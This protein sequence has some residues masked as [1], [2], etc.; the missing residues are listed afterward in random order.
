MKLSVQLFWISA[1]LTLLHFSASAQH[2]TTTLDGR[3][4]WEFGINAG[5]AWQTSDVC[6][7]PGWGAGLTLG[8]NIYHRPGGLLD[9]DLRGRLLYTRTFGQEFETTSALASNPVFNGASGESLNY[10]SN[11][12]FLYQNFRTDL[13]ELSIEGVLTANRL[14][15]KTGVIFSVFGGAGLN[16]NYTRT[17]QLDQLG[18]AYDYSSIDSTQKKRA[19]F[20]DLA[21]LKDKTYETEAE[22]YEDGLR[23]SFMPS[24]GLG[25]GYQVTP[26]FSVG[27]EHK[28]NWALSD[29]LEGERWQSDFIQDDKKDL[30]HYTS[31]YLRWKVYPGKE[32]RHDPISTLDPVLS[33]PVITITRPSSNPFNTNTNKGNV[34][35]TVEHVTDKRNIKV[36]L[37]GRPVKNFS[38]NNGSGKLVTSVDL[39]PGS[40]NVEITATNSV[41]DD[42]AITTFVYN[43]PTAPSYPTTPSNPATSNPTT[44]NNNP[45]NG[46]NNPNNGNN[47]PSN[48][49]P[50]STNPED[51]EPGSYPQGGNTRRP[52]N[53]DIVFPT[54]NPYTTSSSN[55]KVQATITNI[56]SKN[57][58]TYT[59]NNVRS[60]NFTFNPS[61]NSFISNTT[62]K[63]G[64]TVVKITA[65]NS[66]GSDSDTQKIKYT[67]PFTEGP[68]V[69][70]VQPTANPY[71]SSTSSVQIKANTKGVKSKNEIQYTINGKNVTTYT[72]NPTK[73][74]IVA[75]HKLSPGNNNIIIKV[76]N[77]S[78]TDSDSQVVIYNAPTPKPTVT[79]TKPGADPYIA[80]SATTGVIATVTG[81]TSKNDI[82]YTVNG[83]TITSFAYNAENN[84][85]TSSINLVEGNNAVVIQATNSA[86]S[87]TDTRTINYH[88][89]QAKPIVNITTPSKNPYTANSTSVKIVADVKNVN[90]KN[91]IRF[92]LNG[93][94]LTDFT[95]NTTT[96]VLNANVTVKA[97]TNTVVIKASNSTGTDSDSGTIVYTPISPSKPTVNITRPNACPFKST[98][99]STTIQATIKNVD[100]K[101]QIRFVLN[102]KTTT[103]FTFNPSTGIFKAPINLKKGT[104]TIQITGTNSAGSDN[105]NCTINYGTG[106]LTSG[107]KNPPVITYIRPNQQT[108]TVES[109]SYKVQA[110]I[111]GLEDGGNVTFSVN[112]QATNS[113][114]FNNANGGFSSTVSLV[115]GS[116]VITITATNSD[117]KDTES[118][119]IVKVVPLPLPITKI[120]SPPTNPYTSPSA[121][122]NVNAQVTSVTK[123]QITFT[124]NGQNRP[125]NYSE[126]TEQFNASVTLR[127]GTNVIRLVATNA[128]G[129]TPMQTIVKYKEESGD[130]GWG[131]NT[132]PSTGNKPS[133]PK[134]ASSPNVG[135][136]NTGG[137]GGSTSGKAGSSNP[138][139]GSTIP[140]S[141][142]I[143]TLGT[144][145]G[146]TYSSLSTYPL[147]ATINNLADG[148]VVM[149]VN[150]QPVRFILKSNIATASIPLKEGINV[151][152]VTA[153]NAK[154]QGS[155]TGKVVHVKRGNGPRIVIVK[156]K[157]AAKAGKSNSVAVVAAINGISGKGGVQIKV[158][159]VPYSSFSYNGTTKLLKSTIALKPGMNNKI[160]IIAKSKTG[161]TTSETITIPSR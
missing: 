91:E 47:N 71:T 98:A 78:G 52:P 83:K 30:H 26:N 15:E 129:T 58:I 24:A 48:G 158:N 85:L 65:Q 140:T 51:C 106:S 142:P 49:N 36:N 115:E 59:I 159:G 131:S 11:P 29:Q 120:S 86:G 113:F 130:M 22:G 107:D 139:T 5:A 108:V 57:Q 148:N 136:T 21:N 77:S 153:K 10:E 14:R 73:G 126:N 105:D 103:A 56:T 16:A 12:G 104:N 117:G 125:F 152:K 114:V 134:P 109:N 43:D 122:I 44:G 82:R 150:N 70:I 76:S 27:V 112:G 34:I 97:G 81:V 124:V 101:D 118:R 60:T 68:G 3:G 62:W 69:D 137:K 149:T 90:S 7:L 67:I 25:L 53:V 17:N 64:T 94:T 151:I 146:T 96:D 138:R 160:E 33:P 147:K 123:S 55:G 116:N 161:Q 88:S 63:P 145:S 110:A 119:S 32:E 31:L 8:K 155:S 133:S 20:S 92:T 156:P 79:I 39:Y 141:R 9:F 121:Q 157:I 41:G 6:A 100:R 46:N 93:K 50:T 54:G 99:Q 144:L 42:F 40:N 154:G 135:N 61:S 95:Y 111:S 80:T 1:L 74:E 38:F 87:A 37:N 19:I 127:P 66:D 4:A 128:T 75:G 13:G 45:N 18:M 23:W 35:A 132:K 89:P 72:F 143:V 2:T 28:I 102:S 84:T